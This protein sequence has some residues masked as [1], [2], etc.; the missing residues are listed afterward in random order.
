MKRCH[1]S[2]PHLCHT[3]SSFTTEP[4]LI[5]EESSLNPRSL[6]DTKQ[7]PSVQKARPWTA[8]PGVGLRA[9]L[10]T[11][12]LLF[13]APGCFMVGRPRHRDSPSV[14][15]SLLI[16]HP[17]GSAHCSLL[18]SLCPHSALSSRLRLKQA[19][20]PRRCA[21]SGVSPGRHT[22]PL[23]AQCQLPPKAHPGPSWITGWW[24][25]AGPA[26]GLLV[27]PGG[28]RRSEGWWAGVLAQRLLT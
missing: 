7:S 3:S 12:H 13:L 28:C 11:A 9:P 6:P 10:P 25:M 4:S 5:S 17:M 21:P 18:P 19:Q 22:G 1:F 23:P 24:A 15:G 16:D 2:L 26:L 14:D 27:A 20:G 8:R